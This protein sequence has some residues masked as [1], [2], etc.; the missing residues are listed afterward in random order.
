L[1]SL[2]FASWAQT[3]VWVARRDMPTPRWAS[4][5][6]V[7][8]GKIY[9]IGGKAGEGQPSLATVEEYNPATD[10]WRA[11]ANMPTARQWFSASA[12][13]GKCYAIGGGGVLRVDEY[14]P[15]TNTWTQKGNMPIGRSFHTAAVVDGIV[16]VIG[17]LDTTRVEAYNP[18][19]DTWT[20]KASLPSPRG[21]LSASVVN[22]KIYAI[23]GTPTLFV[24]PLATVEEYDP[25]TD[26]WTARTSMPAPRT[27]LSSSAV[28]GK[29]YVIGGYVTPP[30]LPALATNEEYTPPAAEPVEVPVPLTSFA[31]ADLGGGMDGEVVIVGEL[32]GVGQATI[33]DA[34][35]TALINRIDF[36]DGLTPIDAKGITDLNNNNANDIALLVRKAQDIQPKVEVRDPISGNRFKNVD[37]N[38]QHEPIALEILP[39]QNGNQTEEGAVLVKRASDNRPRVLIRDLTSKAKVINLSLPKIFDVF[40]LVGAPDFSGNGSA[41]VLVLA[42]RLSDGKGF[43]LVWDTGGA[44]KVVNVQ[45]PKNHTPLDLAHLTGPGGVA[46]VAVLALRSTDDRGRVL[47]YDAFTAA[48]LWAATLGAGQSPVAIRAYETPGGGRRVA[49][50]VERSSDSKPIVRVFNSNT[51]LVV[52]NIAYNAGQVPVDLVVIPDTSLDGNSTPELGVMVNPDSAPQ[53]RVR[54]S[55]TK[56]LIQTIGLP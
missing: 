47:V 20:T 32:D 3:D 38:K 37:Y 33:R 41:E 49:A 25:A 10:T 48:K 12:V 16:Y 22:G 56:A 54:D 11:R 29:I 4:G 31:V 23:G 50:L 35:T 19:T 9:V 34:G 28:N 52:D 15:A 46:A 7:V 26:T 21:I 43:V 5:T 51:G 2:S 44:G 1:I 55:V 40:D 53:L 6:C 17:G 30:N 13:N 36:T 8:D 42:S 27:V 24:P 14:D 39:D 45:L 18:A